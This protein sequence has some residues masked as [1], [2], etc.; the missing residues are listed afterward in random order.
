MQ[1]TDIQQSKTYLALNTLIH[2]N[3]LLCGLDKL[4][5]T[6][7]Y[8]QHLKKTGN[9]FS[10]ELIKLVDKTAVLD[11]VDDKMLSDLLNYFDKLVTLLIASPTE[12]LVL[13]QQFLELLSTDRDKI[14]N[15]LNDTF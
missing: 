15:I 1:L 13:V 9:E 14:I 12:N 11:G 3:L 5:E 8:R 4:K 6:D 10:K 7:L 2:A